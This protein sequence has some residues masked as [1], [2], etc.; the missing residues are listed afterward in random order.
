M[1]DDA[2]KVFEQDLA[3]YKNGQSVAFEDLYQWSSRWLEAELEMAGDA[4]TRTTAFKTH[5][6]RMKDVEKSTAAMVKAGQVREADA[7]AGRYYRAQAE[8]WLARGRL[9]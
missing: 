3:R 7:A 6:D 2:R 9:R 4:A 5:F 8:L 1:L